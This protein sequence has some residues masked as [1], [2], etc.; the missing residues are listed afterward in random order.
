MKVYVAYCHDRHV[1]PVV[2]VHQHSDDARH[3]VDDVMRDA[4]AHPSMLQR[5]EVEGYVYYLA[6]GEE[7][8]HAFVVECELERAMPINASSHE[9]AINQRLL[10]FARHYMIDGDTMQCRGCHRRIVASRWREAM[11][12]E[13][14]CEFFNDANPWVL[15]AKELEP[16]AR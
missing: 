11:R 15:L 9:S 13:K 14:C 1:D 2:S 7:S 16:L 8:D 6:Y 5:E 3:R 4:V 12:H 10:A